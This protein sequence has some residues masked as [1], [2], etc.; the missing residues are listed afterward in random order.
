MA[1][2]VTDSRTR[3]WRLVDKTGDCW[4]WTGARNG[5]GYGFFNP[6][7]TLEGRKKFGGVMAHRYAYYIEHGFIGKKLV[8]HTCDNKLCV[9][10][11]HLFLAT[12]REN[13]LDMVKKG[14]HMFG[15]NQPHFPEVDQHHNLPLEL[16]R[17]GTKRRFSKKL[18]QNTERG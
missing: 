3:F 14:R 15:P 9:R 18:A 2:R 1:P 12:P 6:V 11:S 4:I 10:P 5:R 7:A 17:V 16:R 8:C 13:S